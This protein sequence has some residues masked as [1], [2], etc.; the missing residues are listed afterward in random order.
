MS[1][2]LPPLTFN[3]VENGEN[4]TFG[5]SGPLTLDNVDILSAKLDSVTHAPQL[6]RLFLDLTN[7]TA[8]D[9]SGI[10]LLVDLHASMVERHKRLYLYR[11]TRPIMTL[12]A[13]LGLEDFLRCLMHEEDLLLR[14]PD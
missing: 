7:V 4:L 2:G 13:E 10:G 9:A 14:M 1:T 6:N 12:I 3:I 11:P 5:F 8:A